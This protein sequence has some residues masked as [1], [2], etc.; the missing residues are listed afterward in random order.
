MTSTAH[1]QDNMNPTAK[2]LNFQGFPPEIREMI[3]SHTDIA[4]ILIR[5]SGR[6]S[7]PLLCV[8][9]SLRSEALTVVY[10]NTEVSIDFRYHRSMALYLEARQAFGDTNKIALQPLLAVT[11]ICRTIPKAQ[12]FR[13][14]AELADKH[15]WELRYNVDAL[16]TW[17]DVSIK[18]F[19]KTAM[20]LAAPKPSDSPASETLEDFVDLH[21]RWC[22]R[23]FLKLDSGWV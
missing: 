13:D 16:N 8:S 2:P 10:K 3:T 1:L 15:Q 6:P 14:W 12:E 17:R 22:D 5:A 4:N 23:F 11:L 19:L 20:N 7:H 9:K 18:C 21:Q